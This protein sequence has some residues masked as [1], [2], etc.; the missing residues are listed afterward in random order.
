MTSLL[1]RRAHSS[2]TRPELLRRMDRKPPLRQPLE[3]RR[4]LAE[5]GNADRPLT[6]SAP[7]CAHV[8]DRHVAT[9]ARCVT[10]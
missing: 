2:V 4:D 1:P 8:P 5:H 9:A 10:L 3:H 6:V 7:D